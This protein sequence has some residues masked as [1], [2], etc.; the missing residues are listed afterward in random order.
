MKKRENSILSFI[1]YNDGAGLQELLDRFQVSKRTLYYDIENINGQ[2]KSCGQI[3][4]VGQ[5]FTYVGNYNML[6]RFING[7]GLLDP[8]AVY[9]R[10]SYILGKILENKPFTLEKLADE[11]GI[12]KNTCI[13]D[14]K[15][16]KFLLKEKGLYLHTK[17]QFSITGDERKIRELYLSLMQENVDLLHQISKQVIDFNKKWN[18][19]LTDYSLGN[20]SAFLVFS[21]SRIDKGEFVQ[22][23]EDFSEAE[24]FPYCATLSELLGT[25]RL[26][27]RQYLS[28]YISSLPSRNYQVDDGRIERYVDWLIEKFESRTAMT[29]ESKE[30]FKSNIK[31]HLLSSYYRIRF[32]FPINN[33]CLTEITI[34]HGALY[35]IIRS[36]VTEGGEEFP[37]LADMSDEEIGFLAAYFGGYLSGSRSGKGSKNRVLLVCPNGL[38]VSKTLKIQLYK[39]IPTVKVVDT[40][41]LS[42][43]EDYL[44]EYDYIIS[45]IELRGYDNVIVVNPIFTQRDIQLIMNKLLDFSGTAHMFD[46]EMLIHV[47]RKSADIYDEEQLRQDLNVLMYQK[48]EENKEEKNP[49]LKDLIYGDRINIVPHV[50]S[51]QDAI[52]LAAKPLLDDNSIEPSYIDAMI[53]SVNRFGPYI[54]LDEYFA[55]PHARLEGGVNRLS[56]SLLIVRN[57]VD[58]LGEAVNVFLVLATVDASSHLDALAN[59]SDILGDRENIHILRSGDKEEILNLLRRY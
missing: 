8:Y 22:P 15:E 28:A 47:I 5:K 13:N 6:R 9:S 33:P 29:I 35:K 17:P 59:L 20:L 27:E 42:S 24:Q 49:V 4:R 23:G 30:E 46:M 21:K 3:R 48:T 2:I 12:S 43:L 34:Q 25:E 18:L 55:L 7:T 10:Q 45:T 54:V 52:T 53:E 58:V 38:M 11:M 16:V 41:A 14:M 26:E 57:E 56:M 32:H 39:Y 51:W 37:E 1:F 44:Q 36:I 31:G 50:E 40:I 19:Q